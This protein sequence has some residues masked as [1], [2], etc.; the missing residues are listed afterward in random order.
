MLTG[1]EVLQFLRLVTWMSP[2]RTQVLTTEPLVGLFAFG[3]N[4][5]KADEVLEIKKST[6]VILSICGGI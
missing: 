4:R 3:G 2:M 5:S 1:V 6:K